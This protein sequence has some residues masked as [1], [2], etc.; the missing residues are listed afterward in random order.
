[1]MVAAREKQ[2]ANITALD[3]SLM[4]ELLS[5]CPGDVYRPAGPIE[6]RATP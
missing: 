1:M 4:M 3:S 6:D 5:F 2:V